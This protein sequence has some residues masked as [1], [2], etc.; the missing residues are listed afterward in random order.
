MTFYMNN[1]HNINRTYNT[2]HVHVKYSYISRID[3]LISINCTS[4]TYKFYNI[5]YNYIHL[6]ATVGFQSTVKSPMTVLYQ[7]H[8]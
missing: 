7:K 8:N 1:E 5:L 2:E 6:M 4:P 3:V